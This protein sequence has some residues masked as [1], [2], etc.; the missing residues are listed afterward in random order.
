MKIIPPEQS[1]IEY[2]CAFPIK[3][4][5][6]HVEGF[7]AAIAHVALQFDPG[8]DPAT[9]EQRPSAKGNYLGLTITITAT[10]R[11]Q[12]DE[13]YRTLTTHPMVKMVL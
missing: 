3:V 1:L 11:D 9:I 8:F 13:L 6:A 10:S 7:A 5:G 12:L 4:M 2:P